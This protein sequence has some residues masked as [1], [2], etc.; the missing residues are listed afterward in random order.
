MSDP[1]P[2]YPTQV[3]IDAYGN[4]GF[5]FAGGSHLG[6]LLFL[7]SGVYAWGAKSMVDLTAQHFEKILKEARDADFVLLGTGEKQIFPDAAMFAL[8]DEA[9]L[10]LE[11]MDTGAACR[12]YNLMMAEKRAVMA[13]LMAVD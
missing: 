3:P 10:G 5:R 1:T 11:V 4:G 7:P 9:G 2:Y 8:F 6:S 12:T 13:A